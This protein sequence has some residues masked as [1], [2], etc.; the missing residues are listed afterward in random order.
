MVPDDRRGL[1]RFG[2]GDHVLAGEYKEA[3]QGFRQHI[4]QFP[5]DE[6]SSDARYWLGE[7]LAA[8]GRNRDAAEVFLAAQKDFPKSK[9]APEMLFKLGVS[10]V[11]L[12]NKDVACATFNQ[13]TKKYP[14]SGQALLA[15]V[16]E[17]QSKA[18]C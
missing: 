11:A 9:K 12:D 2:V 10:L 7:S 13:V 4:E 1:L 15:R 5:A 6:Q 14:K 18:G 16:A 8:Q 17:E 3:E